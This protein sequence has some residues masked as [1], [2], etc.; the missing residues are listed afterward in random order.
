MLLPHGASAQQYTFRQYGRQ[1]GL[2]NG[3][4]RLWVGTGTDLYLRNDRRFVAVRPDGGLGKQMLAPASN[5]AAPANNQPSAEQVQQNQKMVQAATQ[6]VQLIDQQK[7]GE[8]WVYAN[9]A[10]ASRFPNAKQV[11]RELVSFHLDDDH[12]WRVS[13]YTLH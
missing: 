4:G 10:F 9:I 6:V 5:Q 2:T 3:A 1:D 13:G 7:V 11:I 8:V 12:V